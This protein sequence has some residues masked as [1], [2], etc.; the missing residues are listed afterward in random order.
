MTSYS[1]DNNGGGSITMLQVQCCGSPWGEFNP[2]LVVQEGFL[3]EADGFL[4]TEFSFSNPV[5]QVTPV[6]KVLLSPSRTKPRKAKITTVT[7]TRTTGYSV[8]LLFL[9]LGDFRCVSCSKEGC[10]WLHHLLKLSYWNRQEGLERAECEPGTLETACL[11]PSQDRPA[12][13]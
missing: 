12:G 4:R 10:G 3:K 1:G 8:G 11:S 9:T 6:E 7:A 2:G 13:F 5:P